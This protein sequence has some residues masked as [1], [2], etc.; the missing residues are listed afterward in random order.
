MASK[1]FYF[2][3]DCYGV[4]FY[5]EEI[6]TESKRR[7]ATA[8]P[9]S[10]FERGVRALHELGHGDHMSYK[11]N[12]YY[13][14]NHEKK[15]KM[16]TN[17]CEHRRGKLE[18]PGKAAGVVS[19]RSNKR[20]QKHKFT[21]GQLHELDR[22]FQE[23]Q[24]PSAHQRKALAE[25]I[26][27]DESKVKDWFKNN[28]VKYR[29]KQMELLHSNSTSGILNNFS[30]EMNEDQKSACVPEEPVGFILCQQHLG[31]SCWS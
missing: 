25:L 6:V 21:S 4:G 15:K 24:Y 30:P 3:H 1:Y 18:A 31:Q 17:R 10:R 5:E 13:N 14:Y 12:H 16:Q 20:P 23:T 9:C 27:V 22:V 2:D 19:H 8:A 26:H 28:R 29:K 11:Y 7:A